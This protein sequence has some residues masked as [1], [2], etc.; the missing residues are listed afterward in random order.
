MSMMML[1]IKK[2]ARPIP[3]VTARK[4]TRFLVIDA[5]PDVDFV[6]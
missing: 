6:G 3:A 4:K 1:K 2:T 5:P